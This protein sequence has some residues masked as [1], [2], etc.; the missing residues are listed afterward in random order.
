MRRVFSALTLAATLTLLGQAA[1]AT[2]NGPSLLD[3]MT[4][5]ERSEIDAAAAAT[6]FGQGLLWQ[7]QKDGQLITLIGTMHLHDPRHA[8][9]MAAIRPVLTSADLILLEMT[10]VEERQMMTAMV[11]TPEVFFIIEG[12]TLPDQLSPEDWTAL[13]DAA[14]ARQMPGFLAAKSQPWF[15]MVSLAL[16]PCAMTDLI[17]GRFGLDKMIMEVAEGAGIPMAPLEPW[18]TLPGLFADI[19]QAEQLDLL[20]L[21]VLS[22]DIQTEAFVAMLDGYFAG[23]IAQIWEMSQMAAQFVPEMTVAEAEQSNAMVQDLL[24]DR[25]NFA[26]MPVINDAAAEHD[27]MVVAVGAA[28]LP[29]TTGI[30]YLLEQDGWA[31]SPLQ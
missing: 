12:P 28:H 1:S 9:T 17:A 3:R 7:A 15:L 29:G 24:L 26:W 19:P 18:T 23:E 30:L 8:P 6:P 16:P 27:Q 2:C 4:E 10:P 5:Q 13:R 22:P 21:S 11:D 14:R 31:I 20:A 25:R